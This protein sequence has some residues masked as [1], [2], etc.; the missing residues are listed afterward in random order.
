MTQNRKFRHCHA[1]WTITPRLKTGPAF[2]AALGILF[3]VFSASAAKW[4]PTVNN[5]G[6]VAHRHATVTRLSDGRVL[7][8]GGVNHADPNQNTFT[9]EAYLY[10]PTTRSF[11]RTG[12]LNTARALHTA[13]LLQNG[14][15]LIAGGWKGYNNPPGEPGTLN[16]AELY[17][18][19]T[20]SFSYTGYMNTYRGQHTATLLNNGKVLLASGWR[21]PFTGNEAELY[22]PATGTFSV[23]AGD[24]T[25]QRNSHTATLLPDGRVFI[26]GG[27]T[28]QGTVVTDT[29]E[30][31]DPSTDSFISIG[32][33]GN[34]RASH[35]A[36]L[37]KNGKVM[38]VGGWGHRTSLEFY[39][40]GPQNDGQI[41]DPSDNSFTRI[42]D[43]YDLHKPRQWHT[44]TLLPDGSVLIIGGNDHLG[45]NEMDY[46]QNGFHWAF[47]YA[48]GEYYL[49]EAE[50]YLP[51]IEVDETWPDN[52]GFVDAPVMTT[53]RSMVYATLLPSNEVL[54]A[55]GGSETAELFAADYD[56]VPDAT[57]NCPD[58]ANSDQKD[59]DDDGVGDACDNC[60]FVANSNQLD[61]DQDLLGD[62]CDADIDTVLTTPA[63]TFYPGTDFW[64]QAT[65]K[66]DT[67]QPI[68]TI[69][70]D[71]YNTYWAIPGAR[72]LCRRGPA[73]GIPKDLVTIPTGDI[74]IVTCNI[75]EMFEVDSFP[76]GESSLQVAY[77]NYIRDPDYNPNDCS[78]DNDC[79]D[80]FTGTILNTE[81]VPINISNTT[82]NTGTLFV[83][84]DLHTVGGAP[85]LDQQKNRSASMVTRAFDK[86]TGSC[87][88]TKGISWQNYADIY[89]NCEE[90]YQTQ[91]DDL[92]KAIFNLP[93]GNY[94]VIGYYDNGTKDIED[95]DIYI[96]NSVGEVSAGSSKESVYLQVINKV[97]NKKVPAKYRK[98]TGSDLLVIEPEYV[99]WSAESELYPFMFDSIGDWAVTTSVTP[100]EGFVA[101]SDSLGA[102]VNSELEAVQFT[103]TDI[104]SKWVGTKVKHK[105]KHKKQKEITVESEVGIKL[106]PELAAKKGLSIYGEDD[107]YKDKDKDKDKDKPK[108]EK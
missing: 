59:S 33:S 26:L 11:T 60:R 96:G 62:A 87:A 25:I 72:P 99:E 10:D 29:A 21:S 98:F 44:A 15:V 71:C 83:K 76:S 107:S 57:D 48:T 88:A 100:P 68:Q 91:T 50:F 75:N 52:G 55:G 9:N 66:N 82:G 20:G 77:E 102:E 103:I 40:D 64:V 56:G 19:S 16:S 54:V 80:I 85:T 1:K 101:D 27:W 37:L 108:D 6:T 49:A 24:M 39:D 22:D 32:S 18:P 70:P 69:R 7:V 3:T 79:Y 36:T 41:F 2:I 43:D 4:I 106:T 78:E 47:R 73:Y 42:D 8:V 35:T 45:D 63:T 65:I 46:W 17:D 61:S 31:Y 105:I 92:G 104:G 28:N 12:N 81:T 23:T 30:I 97:D 58:V 51:D 67:G 84:A 38:I 13:T 93:A 14:K 95:D 90:Y 89:H 86:S 34:Y 74:Y 5:M 94:L 53:A